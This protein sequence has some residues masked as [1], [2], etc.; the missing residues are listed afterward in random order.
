MANHQNDKLTSR[1]KPR[2]KNPNM[3]QISHT[4][5]LLIKLLKKRKEKEDILNLISL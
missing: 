5:K 1:K 2:K 3:Q 4:V